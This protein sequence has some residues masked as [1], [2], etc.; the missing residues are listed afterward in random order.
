MQ[1]L[2]VASFSLSVTKKQIVEFYECRVFAVKTTPCA[3]ATM[4]VIFQVSFFKAG[5]H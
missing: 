4:K 5:F 3:S 2:T 1:D